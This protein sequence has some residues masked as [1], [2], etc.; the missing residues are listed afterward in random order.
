MRIEHQHAERKMLFVDIPVH[1]KDD[2]Q[3]MEIT[4]NYTGD[5]NA[6]KGVTLDNIIIP[7]IVKAVNAREEVAWVK[8]PPTEQGWYWIRF[9]GRYGE[10][11]KPAN[12]V[13]YEKG[14]ILVISASGDIFCTAPEQGEGFIGAGGRKE[15]SLEFWPIPI[16]QPV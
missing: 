13:F 15:P 14:Q 7:A 5:G 1:H 4:I 10:A 3:T 11:R 6:C 9:N 12:V 8:T 2:P 16:Q